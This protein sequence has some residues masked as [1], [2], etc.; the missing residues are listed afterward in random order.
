MKSIADRV[1]RTLESLYLVLRFIQVAEKNCILSIKADYLAF[2]A[3]YLLFKNRVF[4]IREIDAL[5]EDGDSILYDDRRAM[6][7]KKSF[8]AV[9][10]PH[11]ASPDQ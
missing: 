5:L 3:D 10:K 8:D 11:M 1:I 4:L 7:N 9:K 6:L 2:K